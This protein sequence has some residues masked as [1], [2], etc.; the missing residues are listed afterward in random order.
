MDIHS[1]GRQ[2]MEL[3]SFKSLSKRIT[4]LV[5]WIFIVICLVITATL[6]VYSHSLNFTVNQG[7]H[8]KIALISILVIEFALGGLAFILVILR[9]LNDHI[10]RPLLSLNEAII[11][12]SNKNLYARAA[13][14]HPIGEMEVLFKNF[15]IMTEALNKLIEESYSIIWS[16]IITNLPNRDR[17]L[18]DIERTE[19]PSLI[20]A[21]IDFFKEIND[22]Y[23]NKIGDMILKE[24]AYRFKKMQGE[25]KYRL[26]RMPADEFALLFDCD[27]DRESLIDIVKLLS[28]IINERPFY[29]SGHEINVRVTFGIALGGEIRE[30]EITEGKWRKLATNADMALK[31]AKRLQKNFII[32]DES[33]E[34]IKEY[35]NNIIWKQKLKDAIYNHRIIPFFQPIVNN[36]NGKIEK[37][38]TLVRLIDKQGSI[39]H[40]HNFLDLAKKSHL[41]DNITKAMITKSFAVF[42]N[43]NYEFSINLTVND[44]LDEEIN[45]FIKQELKKNKPIAKRLVFEILESEGIE[46]YKEVMV[47]IEEVKGLGCKI[48]IDDFGSGYSNF[49]HIMRLDVDYIKICSSLIKNLANDRN[50]QII[51]KTIVNFAKELGL[52]TIS[53]YVHSREVYEKGVELG[54]DYSQGFYFGEPKEFLV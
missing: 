6:A 36:V 32:F 30:K 16:D 5:F 33:M 44:I 22:C 9:F 49:E 12:I 14:H 4:L 8:E 11:S 31:R 17:I 51:T 40:P 3:S 48:A 47:F 26:Y 42:E 21:N 37:Y 10:W 52:K 19:K 46:N 28:N 29:L 34:I 20:L 15:N 7:S 18:I 41:Y 54:V 53:E 27:I 43:L 24:T 2:S 1:H 38:E 23:G 35:E 13:H 50:S 45:N 25:L 39:V